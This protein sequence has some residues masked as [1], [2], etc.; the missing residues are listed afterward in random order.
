VFN[1]C[2]QKGVVMKKVFEHIEANAQVALDELTRLCR[3]PSISA[4][5][6]SSTHSIRNTVRPAGERHRS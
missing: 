3:Q 6:E 4:Q 1:V 5:V 2:D